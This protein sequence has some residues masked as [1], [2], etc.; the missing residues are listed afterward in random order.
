MVV[1]TILTTLVTLINIYILIISFR[2]VLSWF[3]TA[4]ENNQ[5][6]TIVRKITDPYLSLFRGIK[7]LRIGIFDLSA[8]I[9]IVVLFFIQILLSQFENAVRYNVPITFS[10]VVVILVSVIWHYL[11]AWI[12]FLLI[13]LCV[14]RIGSLYLSRDPSGR[15]WQIIDT[16][17]QPVSNKIEQILRRDLKYSQALIIASVAFLAFRIGGEFLINQLILLLLKIPV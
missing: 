5:L 6:I 15:I 11:I 17:V 1:L 9:G 8:M 14:V 2:I 12:L 13:I 7:I 4:D 16:V 3:R 10:Y